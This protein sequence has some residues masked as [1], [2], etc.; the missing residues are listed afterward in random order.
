[1]PL[2]LIGI[3]IGPVFHFLNPQALLGSLLA[4]IVSLSVAVI[5]YE[6]GLTLRLSEMTAHGPVV[7][8]MLTAGILI[9]WLITTAA[10]YWILGLSLPISLLLGAIMVITGPT[11]I[12]PILRQT[13]LKPKVHS[14]LK[15]EGLLNDPIGAMFVVIIFEAIVSGHF[16][17]TEMESAPLFLLQSIAKY[18]AIG[19][20]TGLAGGAVLLLLFVRRWVPDYLHGVTSLALVILFFLLSD[21]VQKDSGLLTA[22]I[23]GMVIANQSYVPVKHIIEFKENL[24]ILLISSLFI[25]LSAQLQ[26]ADLQAVNFQ[27][28]VFLLVIMFIARPLAV[29]IVTSNLALNWQERFFIG[30]LNPKGIVAASVAALATMKLTALPNPDPGAAMILPIT[31]FIILISIVIYSLTVTP[32]AK[33]LG[34]SE[35]N[36]QGVLIV[37][38]HYW[39]RQMGFALKNAGHH[40]VLIDTNRSNIYAAKAMSLDARVTSALSDSLMEDVEL[41]DIGYV[42]AVT[43]NDEVNSLIAVHFSDMVH[44]DHI[45]QLQPAKRSATGSKP[46]LASRLRGHILFSPPTTYRDLTERFSE[47]AIPEVFE[48]TEETGLENLMAQY[49]EFL[50][51][52]LLDR[53]NTLHVFT[54]D[55]VPAAGPGMKVVALARNQTGDNPDGIIL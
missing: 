13:H 4:P 55:R 37:G 27:S 33:L 7:R 20:I 30:F 39:A 34:I 6:G 8:N 53:D 15:W 11:V 52:F 47:G 42:M 26:L 40:V 19:G 38:A 54:A 22:V 14:I 50:P 23:M 2:L 10:S 21:F 45:Y 5:L 16:R 46:E 35:V 44:P 29:W 36:P 48:L 9:N 31:F 12:G 17:T 41:G 3:L 32:L 51:L 25:L 1:M 49:G 28:V 24:R 18:V 43:P